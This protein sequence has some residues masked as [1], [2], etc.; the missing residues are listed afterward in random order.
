M[1]L[2][3]ELKL[4]L[5]VG[6]SQEDKAKIGESMSRI[7]LLINSKESAKS[8]IAKKYGDETKYLKSELYGLAKQFEDNTIQK[9]I[10][11]IVGFNTPE[12]GKK[13]IWRLDDDSIARVEDMSEYEV[14]A[15]DQPDLFNQ[16]DEQI[17]DSE[18]YTKM[19]G[20]NPVDF[21]E[22]SSD[23]NE[24]TMFIATSFEQTKDELVDNPEEL[25]KDFTEEQFKD[26]ENHLFLL[27]TEEEFQKL[28]ESG[29]GKHIGMYPCNDDV[30][31]F[32]FE[33]IIAEVFNI[34]LDQEQTE[35]EIPEN[36]D[37]F[38]DKE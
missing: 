31:W 12:K 23:P 13:T 9:E 34:Q 33:P 27:M 1:T 3:K 35:Y 4:W 17:R 32:V 8:A 5:P 20:F 24:T 6:L 15:I 14:K 22:P 26:V 11:C 38:Q 19:F 28:K 7:E 37:R 21:S 18:F 2:Q 29:K 30:M 10:D 36:A 16:E 25:N